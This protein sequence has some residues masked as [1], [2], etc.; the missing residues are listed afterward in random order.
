M[1]PFTRDPF[2]LMT[3]HRVLITVATLASLFYAGWELFRNNGHDPAGA[4]IRASIA[5]VL[6]L[7][8]G[9][10]LWWIKGKK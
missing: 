10:Y 3:F 4:L 2:S 9:L 5:L 7:G 6:A 1:K 8:L